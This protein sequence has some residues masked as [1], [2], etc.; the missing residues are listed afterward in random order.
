MIR[1][2]RNVMLQDPLAAIP[3]SIYHRRVLY[4]QVVGF[5]PY[6]LGARGEARWASGSVALISVAALPNSKVAR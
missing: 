2:T 6:S 5:L 1:S 4:Y 3:S